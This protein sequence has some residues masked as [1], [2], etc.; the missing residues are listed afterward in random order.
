MWL[1]KR[2]RYPTITNEAYARWLRALRPSWLWFF[3]RTELEQEQLATLGDDY[4]A[5]CMEQGAEVGR[6]EAGPAQ[7]D[8]EATVRRVALAAVR[9]MLGGTHGAPAQRPAAA[10]QAPQ[11]SNG[12]AVLMGRKAEPVE[13]TS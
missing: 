11:K 13:D 4:V 8:E 9:Q 6:E 2:D 10:T 3:D 12:D 7:T 5:G 1:F